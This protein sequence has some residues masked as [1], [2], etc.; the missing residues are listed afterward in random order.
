LKECDQT[1]GGG[2]TDFVDM[3]ITGPYHLDHIFADAT[4]ARER[5]TSGGYCPSRHELSSSAI[6]PIEVV[7]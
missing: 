5:R 3:R 7:F 4:T 6:T 2:P 1:H